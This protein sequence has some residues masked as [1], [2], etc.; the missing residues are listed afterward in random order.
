[1][2]YIS[3]RDNQK[4]VTA[5]QAILQGLSEEGGLFIPENIRDIK[6]DLSELKDLPY[7]ELT[8]EILKAFLSDF[9]EEQIE[10]SINFAYTQEKFDTPELVEV[11]KVDDNN[12][13]L[14]LWHGPTSAFKDMAL[15]LL[16]YLIKEASKIAK[17][18]KKITILTATSGDTGKAALEGF[19]NVE[20]V[21]IIV[22]YPKEGVSSVQQK[23]MVT[24]EGQNTH[25]ISV[26]GNFDDTQTGVKKIFNDSK[27]NELLKEN[28]I[29][30]SS[31]N[32]INIG[33]LLPQVVYYYYAYFNLVNQ[34]VVKLNEPVNFVVPSGNFG[35]IL[36]GYYAKLTGLPVN[37]LV[38]ASNKNNI[39]TDFFK[40]GEYNTNRVFHKTMSPSMDI[41]ISSNL[42]R[43]LFDKKQDDI[44]I[45]NLMKDL[46]ETGIF[47]FDKELFNE[48]KAEYA[49]E[50]EVSNKIKE[51][52]EDSNIL[53]DPHTAVGEVVKD[54]LEDELKSYPTIVLSTANPYKFTNS[55]Y[56][57]ISNEDISNDEFDLQDKLEMLTNTKRPKPLMNL[58]EKE[59]RH[60]ETVSRDDMEK[61]VLEILNIQ[62]D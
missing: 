62:N 17:E 19:K 31:A 47:H 55:V 21:E 39:L 42:E 5:S 34:D 1:M 22:F 10:K 11:K 26:E 40:T 23:Q 58:K 28:N 6:F 49:S 61:I 50:E 56:N 59:V 46:G 60:T 18:D 33:R 12:Y 54:K 15:T 2:K 35:D 30:F 20:G 32:S 29:I 43:L 51:L 7:K 16:P 57:S 44:E 4:K 24:T 9:S 41:L 48:F 3:T 38:C 13:I 27:L 8:K 37:L 14:E 25:V 52:F 36:A 45:K 53:I